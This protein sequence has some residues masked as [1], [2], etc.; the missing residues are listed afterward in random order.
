MPGKTQIDHPAIGNPKVR[1]YA[2]SGKEKKN[3]NPKKNQA[4]PG[5]PITPA[6]SN[7]QDSS[8]FRRETTARRPNTLIPP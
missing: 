1:P 6:N 2:G 4:D 8:P 3:C 5:T 7:T